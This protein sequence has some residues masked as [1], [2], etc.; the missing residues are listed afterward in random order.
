MTTLENSER[1]VDSLRMAAEHGP[2]DVEFELIVP[3][4][5]Q[6]AS[7]MAPPLTPAWW[8]LTTAP[9]FPPKISVRF[10]YRPLLV[11]PPPRV[12]SQ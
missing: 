3:A 12:V 4:E 10:P 2:V 1:L 5:S 6:Y 11:F 7:S 8:L 9:S